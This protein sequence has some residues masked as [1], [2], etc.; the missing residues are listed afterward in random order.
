VR[1]GIEFQ[2]EFCKRKK[3]KKRL[4][5]EKYERGMR[6]PYGVLR[7]TN[8]RKDKDLQKEFWKKTK[9]RREQTI[10]L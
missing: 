10:N 3:G 9:G 1:R 6:V 4:A 8:V 5:K 2:N 7:K